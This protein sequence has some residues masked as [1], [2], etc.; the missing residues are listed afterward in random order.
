MA[1]KLTSFVV[2]VAL[3]CSLAPIPPA[4]N[5]CG[6]YLAEAVFTDM[7]G[8][9]FDYGEYLQGRLGIVQPSYYDMFL[10]G[11]YRNLSGTPFTK[12]ELAVL[13]SSVSTNPGIA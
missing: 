13:N 11:A 7:K 12:E 1:R 10:F 3:L 2:V 9:D 6:A 5:A 8:P 4:A